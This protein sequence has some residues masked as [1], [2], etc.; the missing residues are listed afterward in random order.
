MRYLLQGMETREGVDALLAFTK[1]ESGPKI[2][3][4][5]W[6]LIEGAPISRA[7]MAFGVSQSKL[8]EAITT[9]NEVAKKAEKFHEL[10]VHRPESVAKTKERCHTILKEWEKG[11]SCSVGEKPSTCIECTDG[12]VN[13][14]TS[15]VS[16]T[17]TKERECV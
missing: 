10:K 11:C 13:A 1:I 3:A 12:A 2:D 16:P 6:H 4:I 17:V 15:I 8:S 5:Y 7:A 14:L 9:L